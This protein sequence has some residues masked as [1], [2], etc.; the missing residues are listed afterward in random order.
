MNRF[1][2]LSAAILLLASCNTRSKVEEVRAL[3]HDQR[4]AK[5]VEVLVSRALTAGNDGSLCYVG[6]VEA[7]GTTT[8]ISRVPGTLTA[9]P[10]KEGQ[11]VTKG[12][13]L[14]IIESQSAVSAYETAKASLAQAEDG[15]ARVNKVYE[16]GTVTE[17]KYIEI[18]TKLEQARAAEAA[19]RNT[20]EECTVKAPFSGIVEDISLSVGVQTNPGEAIMKIIDVSKPEIHFPLPENEY[21]N[22][23]IGAGANVVIPATGR[24]FEA[25]L[26]AKGA[27]ASRLS[28]SYDCTLSVNGDLRGVMPGMVCKVYFKNEESGKRVIPASAV[29]TDMSGRYVWTVRNDTVGRKYVV[30]SGYI[31]D[32]VVVSAGLD[33][34]DMIIIQ[35]GRKVSTGMKV[36][37]VER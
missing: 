25:A 20:L 31:G 33:S 21:S 36:K 9:L 26:V 32:G 29:K 22:L 28:H 17:A 1:I 35:G 18:K 27:V 34:A 13:T 5:P 12:E 14:A 37:A 11:S 30:I 16:T 3:L 24:V 2:T 19:A 10:V 23:R 6:T 4:E 7:S 8:V 15:W